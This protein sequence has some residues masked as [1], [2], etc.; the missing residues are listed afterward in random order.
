MGVPWGTLGFYPQLLGFH[1]QISTGYM[2]CAFFCQYHSV[3][4]PYPWVGCEGIS[5]WMLYRVCHDFKLSSAFVHTWLHR[6]L[7]CCLTHD[8]TRTHKG[9]VG[10]H[11]NMPVCASPHAGLCQSTPVCARSCQ[12][13]QGH[14]W[15][16]GVMPVHAG[17]YKVAHGHARPHGLVIS[18]KFMTDS[19]LVQFKVMTDLGTRFI[20]KSQWTQYDTNSV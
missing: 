15:P 2:K 5:P 6:C 13:M 12:A 16:C 18:V 1:W 8:H 9:Y 20:L 3:M 4:S 17:P 11:M 7:Q 10:P 19:S 14:T